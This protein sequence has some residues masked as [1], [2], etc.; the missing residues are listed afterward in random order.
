MSLWTAARTDPVLLKKAVGYRV[1][2]VA[3]T[4]LI[5]LVLVGDL[6]LAT[7]IGIAA[8]VAK[9]LLYYGYELA[10]ADRLGTGA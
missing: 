8:N 3:V 5:A 2:S 10:W 9:F 4:T 6:A 1:L 7:N